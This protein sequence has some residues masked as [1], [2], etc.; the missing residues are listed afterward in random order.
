MDT[1]PSTPLTPRQRKR[2]RGMAHA[3]QP[4]VRVGAAGITDAVVDQTDAALAT[5]ELIKVRM[6]EPEDK[7]AMASELAARTGATL[8]GLVG[9]TAILYRRHPERPRIEP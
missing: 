2:L 5:H 7:R 3:L 8:C 6:R 9:H 4:V 1:P